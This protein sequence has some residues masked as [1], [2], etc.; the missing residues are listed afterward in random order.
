[1]SLLCRP[2]DSVAREGC[3]IGRGDTPLEAN[4]DGV[5]P[6]DRGV[7]AGEKVVVE[8]AEGWGERSS[9]SVNETMRRGRERTV[10][11]DLLLVVSALVMVGLKGSTKLFELIPVD[12]ARASRKCVVTPK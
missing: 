6:R 9:S 8:W 7:R 2:S 5:A 3:L 11:E 12:A 4:G 1:M 10:E